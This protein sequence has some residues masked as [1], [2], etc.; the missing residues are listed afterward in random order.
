MHFKF[1]QQTKKWNFKLISVN[2]QRAVDCTVYVAHLVEII[3]GP[4]ID[5]V[6]RA[7]S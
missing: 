5:N 4:E 1:L 3:E 6:L 2:E 7:Q